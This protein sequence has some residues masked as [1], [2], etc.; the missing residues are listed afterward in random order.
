MCKT[1]L[2]IS[3]ALLKINHAHHRLTLA[4]L[5]I[6]LLVYSSNLSPKWLCSF[7]TF[8]TTSFSQLCQNKYEFSRYITAYSTVTARRMWLV[9]FSDALLR[10]LVR[11]QIFLRYYHMIRSSWSAKWNLSEFY[12]AVCFKTSSDK[13]FL[14]CFSSHEHSSFTTEPF[15]RLANIVSLPRYAISFFEEYFFSSFLCQPFSLLHTL[16]SNCQD[17]IVCFK[18]DFGITWHIFLAFIYYSIWKHNRKLWLL[19]ILFLS[20]SFENLSQC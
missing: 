12:L 16:L 8:W 10:N 2:T 17:M 7:C 3:S 18:V 13:W 9:F 5:N 20:V 6:L 19:R 15:N 14:L 1:S 4:L 11:A